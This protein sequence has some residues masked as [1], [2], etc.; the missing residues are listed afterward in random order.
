M[1][2]SKCFVVLA[3]NGRRQNVKVTPDSTILQ[4]LEE[5]CK[6][7]G[8]KPEEYDIKHHNHV[9]DTTQVVRFTGLPN[10][11]FLEMATAKKTREEKNV[12]LCLQLE[13][14][15][16]VTAD[17]HPTDNLWSVIKK[18][19]PDE[20]DPDSNPVIFY[21]RR[22]ISGLEALEETTLRSL[23]L[24]GG[25]AMLRYVHRTS[26]ELH[27][28][29][30][31][32]APLIT[33][34]VEKENKNLEAVAEHPAIINS[35]HSPDSK[36]N[37]SMDV[38]DNIVL[39]GTHEITQNVFNI[40]EEESFQP[41]QENLED[42]VTEA[43]TNRDTESAESVMDFSSSEGSNTVLAQS[44]H[45]EPTEERIILLGERN[46]VAFNLEMVNTFSYEDLPDDFFE[47]TLEDARTV[48]RDLKKRRHELEDAALVTSAQR[49]LQES[50]HVL[51]QLNEYRRV[52]IRIQFPDR[53]VLQGTFV[54]METVSIVMDFVRRYLQDPNIDFHLYTTP[55]KNIL[56]PGKNLIEVGCVPNALLHFGTNDTS[57]TTY[58]RES[59]M[60]QF[61]SPSAATIVACQSR[62]IVAS[63]R[64]LSAPLQMK[65]SK[66]PS[67]ISERKSD[68]QPSTSSQRRVNSSRQSMFRQ[69]G[70]SDRK[71]PKWFK[72]N[73]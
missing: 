24:T 35:K 13:S 10:G 11:A 5:V 55:P 14:G 20:A 39:S 12:T 15:Q 19:S 22:E 59:I 41:A 18:L 57:C 47:L 69:G 61:S 51:K 25:R 33:R 62:G 16:R 48:Y 60:M 58:L 65:P 31:I 34:S 27:Y 4:V 29:A 54:P 63:P 49:S 6:K 36:S 30:N 70:G 46:A 67:H 17:F 32:S 52:V 40:G 9:L 8:F 68:D 2:A 50:V 23:G 42:M 45:R 21:M 53:T 7:Q 1:A 43:S 44:E 38:S 73:K 66:K 56:S 72:P 3:P 37:E 64:P 28:Q 26:E 71:I